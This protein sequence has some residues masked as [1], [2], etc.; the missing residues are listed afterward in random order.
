MALP[1][2]LGITPGRRMVVLL[3]ESQQKLIGKPCWSG[4]MVRRI[5]LMFI[6]KYLTLIWFKEFSFTSLIKF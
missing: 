5:L 3:P 1:M 2:I 6:V 4:S